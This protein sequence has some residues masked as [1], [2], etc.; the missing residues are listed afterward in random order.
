MTGNSTTNSYC[1]RLDRLCARAVLPGRW[2]FSEGLNPE[3]KN[4]S[5]GMLTFP[6]FP[7][8]WCPYEAIMLLEELEDTAESLIHVSHTKTSAT[9]PEANFAA[10]MCH[11][12]L[13]GYPTSQWYTISRALR[14][15]S[16]TNYHSRGLVKGR[17][18]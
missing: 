5:L 17:W 6:R 2:R 3:A 11:G 1:R 13:G 7:Q 4:S 16:L 12:H 15:A 9:I 8:Y 14:L 18:G 10:A